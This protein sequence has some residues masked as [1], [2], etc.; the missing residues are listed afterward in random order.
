MHRRRLLLEVEQL[1][2]AAPPRPPMPRRDPSEP[3]ASFSLER[4]TAPLELKQVQEHVARTCFT[5]P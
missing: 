4:V 5:L 1:R 2:A 3:E